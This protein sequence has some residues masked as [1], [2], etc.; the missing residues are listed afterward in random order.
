MS[1]T[2]NQRPDATDVAVR[3]IVLRHVIGYGQ[4]LPDPFELE[5]ASATWTDDERLVIEDESRRVRDDYWATL[6]EFSAHLSPKEREFS[7]MSIADYDPFRMIDVSWRLEA[8]GM[9]LWALG[10]VENLPSYDTQFGV[11]DIEIFTKTDPQIFFDNA[12]L[13]PQE[14]LDKARDNAEAWNWR[15]RTRQLI[16]D[17]TAFPDDAELASA[18]FSSFDDIVRN[19]SKINTENG[20]FNAIDEDWPAFGK[21]YRDLSED[22]WYLVQ[23][24]TMERHFALNWLCGHAPNNY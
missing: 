7:Q 4:N 13:R 20:T 3:V 18:G 17:G 24:I 12:K 6:G 14:E 19:A 8:L 2:G 1:E 9:L 21:A 10:Y 22:E 11:E 15:S 16:E 5:D 23:S